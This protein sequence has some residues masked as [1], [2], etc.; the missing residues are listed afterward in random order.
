MISVLLCIQN[1]GKEGQDPED[2]YFH[3]MA[4]KHRVAPAAPPEGVSRGG[5]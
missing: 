1:E 4:Q 5:C 2:P 3:M